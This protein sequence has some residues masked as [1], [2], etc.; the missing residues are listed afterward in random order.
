MLE[1]NNQN[2]DASQIQV[3]EGLEAVRK[4]PGMYIGSTSSRGLHHLV[5][6]IVDNSIDEALAGYCKNIKV[7]IHKDNSITVVDDGRGMPVGIHPKMGKPTVEVIMTV[8]HA[9]GKFGGG[10]YKVSGG[11]HGVGASVVNAL[12]ELC[13]VIVTRGGYIWKQSYKR[14]AVLTGL[15]KI[16]EAEGSGTKVHFKPDHEIF[17]ET[18]YDFEILSQRLRELAFLNKGINITLIDEREDEVKEEVY[19]YEGGIKSFV[20][21]LN[22]NKE[23][24]H[25]EPIYVEGLKDGIAVEVSLQYHDGFNENIFTFAN[26]IDTVE[27]G[28]HL[29]G[30]KTALTRVMNDY[31]RRFGHL[32]ESDKNL[33]G[34]DIREGL[35]AVVSVKISEPQFEGQTKTKLGNS[36]ARS[37][38]DS[39]SGEGI[40]TFLEE[41]P[42]VGKI[43]IEK[44]LLASRARE[45]ARRARELTRKSVLE[46]SS[47]PGK[48][49]DCSSKDPKECEI[50]IVEGDSAGGSAKQGRDRKFQAI[51]PLRGKIMN[52]EKQ[53]L[54]K[55]LGS[56]TIRS[57]VTAI[58][59][60]IGPEFDIE[61]IRYNRIIIMTDADVDGA[62]IRTLLLTFF[63][64]YMRDL[65]E[66]GHVYI[67][68]PPLYK[69]SKGKQERYA[70]SDAAADEII[71]EFGGKDS[72]VNVQRYK[73][74]GEMN[75]GQL[76]ET[77]MD[78]ES[79][80]LLR[81]DIEDA[82]VADEIFTILMGD[83]VEPR[84][85]FIQKNAKNVSNL[86]I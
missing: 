74:L 46:R 38:V 51:L 66:Q 77:T 36:E 33:S 64:R 67:A 1:Q 23:V 72:S 3:L 20:S 56:D 4:R 29:A 26:N 28:T 80:I 10:G 21:Y 39:I 55:I 53:R 43:I 7:Y 17:E 84:R 50:Y 15:E 27:G 6:E 86:D 45:A 58:G 18:E 5:Y 24:L 44:A 79:R 16:G 69:I 54:D 61:K 42:E 62:H 2:Y 71:E 41:N 78:P 48:L 11:L 63:Y 37:A 13:E 22:R 12:S 32:K 73:G 40:S 35:T 85:E 75:A 49:A 30:F 81:A 65:V 57:M 52:V 82:M 70:Y 83:K 68:Q 19:H 8:L 14:G 47:L 34:D 25:D 59:A 60:G 9:G 31:G 76:W